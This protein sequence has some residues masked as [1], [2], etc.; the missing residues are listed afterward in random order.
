MRSCSARRP[1]RRY[2][3]GFD[4]GYQALQQDPIGLYR[5]RLVV[6]GGQPVPERTDMSVEQG[7]RSFGIFRAPC[8]G[9]TIRPLRPPRPQ[10]YRQL[11]IADYGMTIMIFVAGGTI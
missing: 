4:Q 1:A 9:S 5:L 2:S 8:Y 6:F 3:G 10:Y 7:L 11:V